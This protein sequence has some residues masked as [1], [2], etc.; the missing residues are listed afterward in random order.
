M[1]SYICKYYLSHTHTHKKNAI[2]NSNIVLGF[3]VINFFFVLKLD[4]I[5]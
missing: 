4:E 5:M 1:I 3:V 2:E